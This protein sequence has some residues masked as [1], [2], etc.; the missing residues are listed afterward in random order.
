M[1]SKYVCDYFQL[2]L[3]LKSPKINSVWVPKG[4]CIVDNTLRILSSVGIDVL[5]I[6]RGVKVAEKFLLSQWPY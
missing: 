4:R 2:P 1:K 6:A 3:Q 5:N